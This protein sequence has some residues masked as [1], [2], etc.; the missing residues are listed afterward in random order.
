MAPI[1][2]LLAFFNVNWCISISSSIFPLLP[3]EVF[4]CSLARSTSFYANSLHNDSLASR[5]PCKF[6]ACHAPFSFGIVAGTFQ[7]SLPL[8]HWI[9]LFY[10]NLA[11]NIFRYQPYLPFDACFVV[12]SFRTS[13]AISSSLTCTSPHTP[14]RRNANLSSDEY[15]LYSDDDGVF[16]FNPFP[17]QTHHPML[18]LVHKPRSHQLFAD[19]L[20]QSICLQPYPRLRPGCLTT[21]LNERNFKPYL[22][23][24]NIKWCAIS[25]KNY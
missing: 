19:L 3:H 1:Q 24:S 7:I 9:L 10:L 15:K 2:R 6:I 21:T 12:G 17:Q 20:F 16:S 22:R 14:V 13:R 23:Q 11:A 18:I 8:A 5:M 25:T 4:R